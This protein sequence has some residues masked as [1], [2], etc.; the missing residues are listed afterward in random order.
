MCY[1]FCLLAVVLIL[2]TWY[3]VSGARLHTYSYVCICIYESIYI[4]TVCYCC[5]DTSRPVCNCHHAQVSQI[6]QATTRRQGL[7]CGHPRS[8]CRPKGRA[9]HVRFCTAYHS[10]DKN[11]PSWE[12]TGTFQA[13]KDK[14]MNSSSCAP[15]CL[16]RNVPETSRNNETRGNKCPE[17]GAQSA[18]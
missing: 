11:G 2:S 1:Q 13:R 4:Y 15:S 14:F 10:D 9:L 16:S 8:S 3:A 12:S 7:T 18:R 5:F 6:S 17:G